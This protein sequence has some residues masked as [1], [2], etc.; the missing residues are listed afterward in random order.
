MK[1]IKLKS[2]ISAVALSGAMLSHS[3]AADVRVL[4]WKGYGTDA[5]WAVDAFEKS[6]GNKVVHDYFNS[7]QEMLTKLRTNP[8]AFDVVLINSAYTLA[9]KEEGLIAPIDVSSIS[10]FGDIAPNMASNADLAPGGEV[11][12]V[13]WTWGLTSFAI[14]TGSFDTAPD[15]L[16]VFWNSDYKGKIGWRDDPL[17]SVQMS[18]L[19]TGQDINNI[20]D[21]DAIKKRLTDLMPQIKTFWSSEGDWNQFMA[22]GDFAAATIWSGSAARSMSKGLPV[23]FVVPKEGAIGWLDGLSIPES[24]T[25]KEAAAAFINWMID[26]E[27]YTRWAEEGAPASANAKAAAAL[28][29]DNFNRSVLGDPEVVARVQFM[30]PVSDEDRNRYL[31]MWQDL[32]ATQ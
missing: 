3:F 24:S 15:S 31:E 11:Y 17:E 4:N 22:A 29:E 10:H 2:I 20:S 13:P 6:T 5:E 16:E 25:N 26:P 18:A 8:G 30:Q 27:F 9:A 7:E 28:P 32:K 12:G 19:V 23:Q 14:N 21:M 1:P